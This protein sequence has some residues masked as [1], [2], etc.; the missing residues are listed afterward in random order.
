MAVYGGKQVA[1][2][3]LNAQAGY[4][5]HINESERFVP[6][7]SL[8]AIGDFT[9]HEFSTGL[10]ASRKIAVGEFNVMPQM[11]LSYLHLSEDGFTE[12]G[13]G[14]L[15]VSVS[16]KDTHSM[17]LFTGTTISQKFVSAAGYTFI[18]EFRA[19][20]S[21]EALD[22]GSKANTTLLGTSFSFTGA[23]PSRHT[24]SLGGGLTTQFDDQLDAYITYDADL[25][26][27]NSFSQSFAAGV[28]YRF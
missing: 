28:K 25:P 20:Y 8:T 1:G 21:Y 18:P 12:T 16:E 14:T 11:G 6:A 10:Q 19:K 9:A 22:N 26:T 2:F 13:A 27:S 3:N 15:N 17:R 24:V 23:T 7:N 5:F 4:A